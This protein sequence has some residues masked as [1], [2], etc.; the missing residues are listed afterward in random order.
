MLLRRTCIKLPLYPSTFFNTRKVASFPDQGIEK[1][2]VVVCGGGIAGLSAAFHLNKLNKNVVLFDKYCIGEGSASVINC[3][4]INAPY[5]WQNLTLMRLAERSFEFYKNLAATSNIELEECGK[6][7]LASSDKMAGELKRIAAWA[8]A[9]GYKDVE[10]LD[11]PSEML[12]RWPIADT[13][14][15]VLALHSPQD[16]RLDMSSVLLELQRRLKKGGVRIYEN[17]KVKNVCV[18]NNKQ[19]YGIQT[20]LGLIETKV[21]VDCSGI[22]AGKIPVKSLPNE[23]VMVASYPC[24]VNGLTTSRISSTSLNSISPIICDVESNVFLKTGM[25]DTIC[26]GFVEDSMKPFPN[27]KTDVTKEWSIPI[28]DWDNF[29]PILSR[30]IDRFPTLANAPHGNL[31][32]H[33]DTFTPDRNPIIGECSEVS[34]YYIATGFN[35]RGLT[36]APGATE[37][38]SRWIYKMPIKED[39]S[40]IDVTRFLPMHGNTKY[41]FQRVP[42]VASYV[43][44][45]TRQS[46]QFHSARNLRMS[47]IYHQ[48]RDAGGVF[49][50]LMGYERPLWYDK[51]SKRDSHLYCGQDSLYGKPIWF[52]HVE[53]EYQAC[54]ERVG[55][56]DMTSF[57]KFEVKGEDSERFLQYLCSANVNMPIGETVYTGMQN[58]NGGYVTDCTISR[59]KDNHYFVI[60]PT[61]QQLRC[62]I[63]MKK[64]ARKLNTDV[65]IIDVTG[66]YTALDIIGPS[67]RYLMQDISGE[68]MSSGDFPS[69]RMKEINIGMGTGIRANSI[70]HCGELGWM[71][72]IPNEFAQNVYD[73]I[74]ESGKEYNMKHC[75]YYTMRHLRIEKFY[76]YWGQDINEQTTPVECGRTFRVDFDKSEFIGKEALLKQVEEGVNK[77]FVQIFIEDHDMDMDPWPQGGEPILC[78]GKMCGLTTSSAYGFTLKKQICL[79]YIEFLNHKI[80]PSHIVQESYTINI[81]GRI[82]PI[83][84]SLHSPNLPMISSEHPVHY[85]PTQD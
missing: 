5:F 72:Y 60:A 35:A 17:C 2:D 54:R 50:E 15:V 64:W 19:V 71:L 38:L 18:G 3:G 27:T 63:W 85:A 29:Q 76:V 6:V 36:L 79:G 57:S 59:L 75:G 65:K 82:F 74:V 26:G 81:G 68:S 12:S 21:F 7:Y 20:D 4:L 14:D 1:A 46:F 25:Y 84:V 51:N 49:G 67:G 22:N 70:S 62:F 42:E 73:V 8:H 66:N 34:G 44:G 61:V 9:Y 16:I 53:K 31:Q 10:L 33:Y 80:E 13:E 45:N 58:E 11:C 40:T 78:N 41:L 43:Y 77:R 23:H 37:L 24:T 30:L 55:L 39:V 32:L 52:D 28:C 83:K 69:F 48:L 47:P 56:I